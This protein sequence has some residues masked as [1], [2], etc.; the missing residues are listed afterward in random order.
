MEDS[1]M[2][3]GYQKGNTW[4]VD[5]RFDHY[6]RWEPYTML[7]DAC[8][9]AGFMFSCAFNYTSR[10]YCT[11]IHTCDRQPSGRYLVVEHCNA[12]DDNPIQ[13][14]LYALERHG[15][16]NVKMRVACLHLEVL[17][18]REKLLPLERLGKACDEL[19][20][21]IFDRMETL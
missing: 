9:E 16:F 1:S 11:S 21:A 8:R 4:V 14:V 15:E 7:I 20:N 17:M 2:S 6:A 12:Y 3:L 10:R 19:T 5:K 18:L 13:S